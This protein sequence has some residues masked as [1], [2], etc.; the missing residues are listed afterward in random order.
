MLE[1]LVLEEFMWQKLAIMEYFNRQPAGLYT[2][3]HLC[4]NL[5]LSY[6]RASSITNELTADLKELF[7]YQLLD[8][9]HKLNWQPELYHHNSYI[10]HLVKSSISYQ[11]IVQ[12]LLFPDTSFDDFCA[13]TFLSTS[14][15]LR[16]LRPLK[17]M[18]ARYQL[19][20][21]PS[22]MA[23]IGSESVVRMFY[24][25]YLWAGSHS[26]DLQLAD[27]DLQ[28]EAQLT[29]ELI[30]SYGNFMHP[31]ELFLRLSISRIRYEQGHFLAELP[32]PTIHEGKL[33]PHLK[34]YSQSF[35]C[36]DSQQQDHTA[37]L[38][39][40]LYLT[41]HF[42]SS[43]DFRLVDLQKYLTSLTTNHPIFQ[44][45]ES[46]VDF[47]F[48]QLTT[49]T[50]ADY[51]QSFILRI[52]LLATLMTYQIHHMKPPMILDL[53]NHINPEDRSAFACL[54]ERNRS[55]IRESSIFMNF[56][57]LPEAL[58]NFTEDWTRGVFTT[59][60]ECHRRQLLKV[61]ITPTPDHYVRQT[62]KELLKNLSFIELLPDENK[63][64]P[65]DF[66]IT[67]FENLLLTDQSKTCFVVNLIDNINCQT[68][69]FSALWHAYT[70][71]I[72]QKNHQ[73]G[74]ITD[75]EK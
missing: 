31:K 23:I 62:L 46:Y 50:Q 66:Y 56:P 11:F 12:T 73:P 57:W 37:F 20:L 5:D 28:T 19:T 65:A 64:I 71:L 52:N 24:G 10:Q 40:S 35:I 47:F 75:S 17:E 2:I 41:T 15:V 18:M 49:P 29:D 63:E 51:E 45:I 32:K 43:S 13:N 8:T 69:L 27:F 38:M 36:E 25:T 54:R 34:A 3:N 58:T 74:Y 4:S 60:K 1:P 39:Y 44:A 16:K 6:T 14:T 53:T 33:Y 22:K 21:L 9:N 72:Q 30:A 26:E 42:T 68:E 7:D 67:T 48:N 55:F 59:Y 61:Q 70:S